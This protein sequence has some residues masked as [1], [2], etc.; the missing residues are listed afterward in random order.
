MDGGFGFMKI[1]AK[2]SY[3]GSHYAGFQR[4][5]NKVSIQ[6]ELERT[7]SQLASTEVLI[8]GAG[9]T[10]A[11]VSALGQVVSFDYPKPM[12][13]LED[14]RF[15]WN[16]ILP[17]DVSIVK[18]IEVDDDFDARHACVGKRYRYRFSVSEKHP[19]ENGTV[20]Y[21]GKR[22]FDEVTFMDAMRL[23]EGSHRFQNFTTKAEDKDD[24][25]RRVEPIIF[26]KQGDIYSVVLQSNG[27]MTY[28]IRFMVGAALK[29]GFGKIEASLIKERLDATE[30]H[31]LPYK[32][33]SEGLILEEVLYGSDLFA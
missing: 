26:E 19:L 30:R 23:F 14:F 9:R 15:H 7:L 1:A 11:G 8:H 31:I 16:M 17:E 6:G 10:D 21:L 18:V 5:K 29:V 12:K 4:Q 2:V 27:F 13:S 33:P 22:S 24:Y 32:A 3:L 20:A 28:Q 25:L